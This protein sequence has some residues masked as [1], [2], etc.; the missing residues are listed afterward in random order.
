[1]IDMAM[2]PFEKAVISELQGIKKE[3]HE[4]NRKKAE[5][6]QVDGIDGGISGG[7]DIGAMISNSLRGASNE[8]FS[9]QMG[10]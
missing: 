2:T 10:K 6:G 7:I 9:S 4:M 8:T 1:M 5:Q 3:L